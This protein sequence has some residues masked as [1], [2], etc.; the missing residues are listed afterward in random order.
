MW[1]WILIG[2]G[3]ECI[4]AISNPLYCFLWLMKFWYVWQRCR[5]TYFMKFIQNC[6]WR[7]DKTVWYDL[8]SSNTNFNFSLLFNS[9]CSLQ[10]CLGDTLTDTLL[11]R[12]WSTEVKI[13]RNEISEDVLSC[14]PFACKLSS[15]QLE[16]CYESSIP[17][18][19]ISAI[20]IML[21]F[22]VRV[23]YDFSIIFNMVKHWRVSDEL[24]WNAWSLS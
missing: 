18:N 19:M 1:W 20:I 13:V 8:K 2:N 10:Q 14:R 21:C 11:I 24:I 6:W 9:T 23:Q 7:S 15:K 4:L 16:T 5:I 12:Y 3:G 22:K 17:Y